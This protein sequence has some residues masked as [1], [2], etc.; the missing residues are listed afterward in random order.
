M[1]FLSSILILCLSISSFSQ[2]SKVN[3]S[4]NL[5]DANGFPKSQ[6]KQDSRATDFS[7]R[8]TDDIVL[9]YADTKH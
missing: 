1:K 8:S 6:Q 7:P 3:G 5:L 2:N 9:G 4:K